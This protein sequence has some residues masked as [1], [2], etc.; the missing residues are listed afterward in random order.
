MLQHVTNLIPYRNYRKSSEAHCYKCN[1]KVATETN[2]QCLFQLLHE[3]VNE[4]ERFRD[5]IDFYRVLQYFSI[6]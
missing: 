4:K 3:P 6:I 2:I 5:V 1:Q